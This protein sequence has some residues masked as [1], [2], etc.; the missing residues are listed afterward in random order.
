VAWQKGH[1]SIRFGGGVTRPQDNQVSFQYLGGLLFLTP[2]D[3]L[4]GQAGNPTYPRLTIR[5][6]VWL[7]R[8]ALGRRS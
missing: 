7:G 6:R 3:F 5:K 4:L 8:R 1:H 2:S